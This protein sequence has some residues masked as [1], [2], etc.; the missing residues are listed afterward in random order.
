MDIPKPK[1]KNINK[2]MISWNDEKILNN[3][4]FI[5]S[6]YAKI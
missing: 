2:Q 3:I 5:I 1:K 4:L 6:V